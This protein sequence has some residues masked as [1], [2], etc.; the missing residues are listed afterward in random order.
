[1]SIYTKQVS[2]KDVAANLKNR[3]VGVASFAYNFSAATV[4]SGLTGLFSKIKLNPRPKKDIK[5]ELS[6]IFE[7]MS[8]QEFD[9]MTMTEMQTLLI[10]IIPIPTV[11]TVTINSTTG[12]ILEPSK[13]SIPEETKE[14]IE[15]QG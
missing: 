4:I 9:N 6:T 1:M 2:I 8:D 12:E 5:A 14:Q 15:A 11:G 10:S 7:D 3:T 13:S